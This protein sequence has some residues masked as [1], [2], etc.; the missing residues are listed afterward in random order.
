MITLFYHAFWCGVFPTFYEF[1]MSIRLH[2]SCKQTVVRLGEVV[3]IERDCFL[4]HTSFHKTHTR[5]SRSWLSPCL[6]FLKCS[7]RCCISK[8]LLNEYLWKQD[9]W[10]FINNCAGNFSVSFLLI[11][12]EKTFEFA[13]SSSR[14][15]TTTCTFLKILLLNHFVKVFL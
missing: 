6:S 8:C 15:S 14:W 5:I 2:K 1:S 13:F 7:W 3:N 10:R 11:I 9:V 12:Y 4:Y